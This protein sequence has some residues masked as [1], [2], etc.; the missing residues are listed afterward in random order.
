[1]DKKRSH[2]FAS[3]IDPNNQERV[4]LEDT[5]GPGGNRCGYF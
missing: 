4:E 5:V 3:V 2:S 1:M